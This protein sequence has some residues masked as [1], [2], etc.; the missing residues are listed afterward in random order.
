MAECLRCI[1]KLL[2]RTGNFF[3]EHVKVIREAEHI[4][5]YIDC[6]NEIFFV[7]CA[8]LLPAGQWFASLKKCDFAYPGQGFD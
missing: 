5:E 3:R 4:F 6:A 2:T 7:V 1:P 8:S